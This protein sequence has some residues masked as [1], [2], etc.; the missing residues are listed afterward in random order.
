MKDRYL[1]NWLIEKGTVAKQIEE[2]MKNARGLVIETKRIGLF[3]Y[4]TN[5]FF[6]TT[7]T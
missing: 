7:L 2:G 6:L 5:N 4:S 1:G 3:F